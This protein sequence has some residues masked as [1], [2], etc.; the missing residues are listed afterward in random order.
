[1]AAMPRKRSSSNSNV[2]AQHF[3]ELALGCQAKHF[4]IVYKL[5]FKHML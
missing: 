1:M 5:H 3:S 4:I 2:L